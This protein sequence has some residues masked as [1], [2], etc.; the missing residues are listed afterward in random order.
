V[1]DVRTTAEWGGGHIAG[2]THAPMAR[3]V[4][5]M[6]NVDRD[7]PLLAYSQ[8]GARSRVAGTA[9]RRIGF[10][11]VANLAGGF[12]ACPPA[13]TTAATQH[14]EPFELIKGR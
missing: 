5:V 12:A 1:L 2:A 6:R 4:D 10:T 3:L 11:H 9:L 8:T 7:T 13:V 14:H